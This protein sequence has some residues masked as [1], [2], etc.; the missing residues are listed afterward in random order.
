MGN[1][2]ENKKENQMQV[3]LIKHCYSFSNFNFNSQYHYNF[4]NDINM[5][6]LLW[7]DRN[8]EN[9]ENYGYQKQIRNNNA[10]R[11]EKFTN[12]SDLLK[13]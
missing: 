13:N 2:Q 6:N 3:Q 7:I 9:I 5:P 12:I 11:F 10:F 4:S 1:S 8:V